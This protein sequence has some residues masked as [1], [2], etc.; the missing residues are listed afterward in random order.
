MTRARHW[1]TMGSCRRLAQLWKASRGATIVE[2][3][4]VAPVLLLLLFGIFDVGYMVYAEAVLH[5]AAE[6]AARS[7]SLETG[8]TAKADAYVKSMIQGLLPGAAVTTSRKSYYDFNDIARPE[9]WNDKNNNNTCDNGEAYTDENGNGRWDADIGN[10]GNGGADDVVV[11]TVT[12]TYTP[13]FPNPFVGGT[14]KS[15]TLTASTVR[16]NQPYA[17]QKEYGASAGTC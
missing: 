9:V 10:S 12:V 6:Q 17:T 14:G 2:F 8:D 3:A 11:Y 4:I 5:G 15:R 1:R 13:L 7:S 16:K